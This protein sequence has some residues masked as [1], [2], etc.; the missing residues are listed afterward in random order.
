VVLALGSTGTFAYWTDT[1]SLSGTTFT[2]GTIDLEI[3]GH[4]DVTDYAVLDI[5]AMVPGDSVAAVLTIANTGTAPL[6]YTAATTAT[7]GDGWGLAGALVVKVTG[8]A[9]T[10]GSPPAAACPGTPV[11]GGR[12]ALGGPLIATGRQ[13]AAAANEKI[14]VQVTLPPGAASA[15]QGATTDVVLAFTGTSDLS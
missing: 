8:D 15:L 6:K 13:L 4:D 10:A 1:A 3:D 12:T 2:A 11:P 14:C 5:D 9:A 7:N